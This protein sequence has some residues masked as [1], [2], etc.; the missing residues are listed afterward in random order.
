MTPRQ[1]SKFVAS[2]EKHKAK[3]AKERDELRE[4]QADI[5]AIE[6]TATDALEHLGYAI[7]ALS[8]YV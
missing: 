5:E 3:L 6:E 4:L 1:I 8:E 7:D 2:L